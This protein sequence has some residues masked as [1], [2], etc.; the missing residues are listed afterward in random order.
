MKLQLRR[1]RWKK[2]V[3]GD[4]KY[5]KAMKIVHICTSLEGGTGLTAARIICTTKAWAE[6]CNVISRKVIG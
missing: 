3:I 6:F 4:V 1:A 2:H 5:F